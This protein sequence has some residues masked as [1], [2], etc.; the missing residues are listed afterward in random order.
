MLMGDVEPHVL[1]YYR[2]VEMNQMA[3]RNMEA[4]YEEKTRKLKCEEF[5]NIIATELQ[6]NWHG[7]PL[8]SWKYEVNQLSSVFYSEGWVAEMIRQ[9]QERV[10]TTK[11]SDVHSSQ[12]FYTYRV[13]QERLKQ[14]MLAKNFLMLLPWDVKQDATLKTQFNFTTRLEAV[15]GLPANLD[16][17][18][19]MMV[20]TN[21]DDRFLGQWDNLFAQQSD[22]PELLSWEALH[23]IG[24]DHNNIRELT[25]AVEV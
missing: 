16:E 14:A 11:Y 6:R 25:G 24:K 22:Q 19:P 4:T 21:L 20:S 17:W 15:I 13:V 8:E 12:Y 9:N 23:W 10:T 3:R 2:D 5:S 7:L 1:L 18:Q